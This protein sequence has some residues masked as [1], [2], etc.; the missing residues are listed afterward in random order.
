MRDTPDLGPKTEGPIHVVHEPSVRGLVLIALAVGIT[1]LLLEVWPIVVVVVVALMLVGALNPLVVSLERRGLGRRLALVIVF[2]AVVAALA[3]FVV[4]TFPAIV[5]GFEDLALHASTYQRSLAEWLEH[6]S[7]LRSAAASVRS[8]RAEQLFGEV[9]AGLLAASR[10]LIVF[11]GYALSALFL[12]AYLIADREAARGTL[13]ALFPRRHHVRLARI[14]RNLGTIVGG[15]VRGQVITSAAA[16]L[17]TFT[18]LTIVGVPDAT[19]LA[20][21]AAV[22]DILPFIG[23][24]LCTAPAA[25]AALPLGIVPA[26]IVV[27]LMAVYQELENRLLVPRVY[28]R[29]LRLPAAVVILALLAGG[30]LLGIVGALLA[31]PIAAGVRMA[32]RELRVSMPGDPGPSGETLEHDARTEREYLDRVE[33]APAKEAAAIAA[34]IADEEPMQPPE[35]RPQ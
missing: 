18:L 27:V 28:G 21:F 24:F 17:F 20:V 32:I 7:L 33:G 16:G 31:I 3:A 14:L 35:A 8:A 19:A 4:L 13:Y 26:I 12:A 5:K 15:Y 2:G 9:A 22:T 6:S 25:L 30:A 10:D 34:E 1:V 29:V 23:G 11:V